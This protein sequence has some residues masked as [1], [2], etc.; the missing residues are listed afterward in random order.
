MSQFCIGQNVFAKKVNIYLKKRPVIILSNAFKEHKSCAKQK[1][2]KHNETIDET[3]DWSSNQCLL[4]KQTYIDCERK[5][6][7]QKSEATM[8]PTQKP[9]AFI[10]KS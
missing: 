6:L 7:N 10:N 2:A 8:K 5:T 1:K 9:S 3:I 4:M